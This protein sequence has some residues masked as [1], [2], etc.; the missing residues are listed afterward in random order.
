MIV[1]SASSGCYRCVLR[2]SVIER[3]FAHPNRERRLARDMKAAAH[4]IELDRLRSAWQGR[5]SGCLLG[6]P[7]E[8]LSFGEGRGGVRRYYG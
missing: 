6:K 2:T 1:G 7:L 3:A 4:S 5:V 8:V